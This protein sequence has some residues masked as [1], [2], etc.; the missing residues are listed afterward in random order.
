MNQTVRQRLAAFGFVSNNLKNYKEL[1]ESSSVV[2]K[3]FF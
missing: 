2:E 3:K 1:K